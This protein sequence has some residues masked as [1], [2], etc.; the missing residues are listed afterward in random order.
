MMLPISIDK[1]HISSGG[2]SG[3][4][5]SN[6]SRFMPIDI[7]LNYTF[8]GKAELD[9]H[10]DSAE[11][12]H[13]TQ[14][15]QLLSLVENRLLIKFEKWSKAKIQT[16]DSTWART[17]LSKPIWQE[18][19]AIYG[20]TAGDQL[21]KQTNTVQRFTTSMIFRVF[22]SRSIEVFFWP[23]DHERNGLNLR[24]GNGSSHFMFVWRIKTRR[25][26]RDELFDVYCSSQST[27]VP[28]NQRLEL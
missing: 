27:P 23:F 7:P 1:L 14:Y 19:L 24:D 9:W 8:Y 28:A 2:T 15:T 25:R 20:K 6:L 5:K 18:A 21:Q 11:N 10:Q 16:I 12:F 13:N 4:T 3:G 17:L 22:A 26:E